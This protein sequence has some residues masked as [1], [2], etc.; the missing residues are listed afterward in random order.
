MSLSLNFPTVS[1]SLNLNFAKT[2]SLDPRITFSRSSSA[3]YVDSE[4]IVRT[5]PVNRARFQH[6]YNSTSGQFVSRGLLIEESRTN[7]SLYSTEFNTNWTPTNAYTIPNSIQSPDGTFTGTKL[8]G[9]SGTTRCRI[10]RNDAPST[11]GKIYSVYAKA[12]EWQYIAI[13]PSNGSGVWQM[14]TFN[15]TTGTFSNLTQ[16]AVFTISDYGIIPVGNG[17]YRVWIY[18]TSNDANFTIMPVFNTGDSVNP[19]WT[20]NGTSGI[21]IWGAQI[22]VGAFP[23]SYIPT[24][25][26]FTSRASSATFYN[27]S[28]ILQTAAT[29]VARS[30]AYFPDSSGVFRSAR[31]LLESA[32]TNLFTYSEDFSNSAWTKSGSNVTTNALLAPDGSYT[33][34]F[35]KEDAGSNYHFMYRN[36]G[37]TGA[38]SFSVY[39]KS[40]TFDRFLALR[41]SVSQ[42]DWHISVFDLSNG[43]I[44]QSVTSGSSVSNA[45]AF[46]EKLP[47]GWYR[48]TIT[49]TNLAGSNS[50]D[51][52]LHNSSSFVPSGPDGLQSY[53]GN[54]TSGIYIWGAQL[55]TGSVA[56][57]YIKS[58]PTFTSRASSATYVDVNGTIRTAAINE[59]RSNSYLPDS[60]GVIRSIGFLYEPSA[61]NLY[62]Y[63]RDFS[64]NWSVNQVTLSTNAGLAPDGTNTAALITTNTVNAYNTIEQ[65]PTLST[66]TNYCYSVFVKLVSGSGT[67]SRV[68]FGSASTGVLPVYAS[69]GLQLDTLAETTDGNTPSIKGY[70]IYP[71][72]WVR[73]YMVI[74]TSNQTSGFVAIRFGT[75]S[76][77]SVATFYVWGAQLEQGTFPTS[78]IPTDASTVTR[79]ADVVSSSTTTRAADVS[80]SSSVTRAAESTSMTGA[81]F[82][83]WYNNTEGTLYTD[84]Q[85]YMTNAATGGYFGSNT[86]GWGIYSNGSYITNKGRGTYT[87]DAGNFNITVNSLISKFKAAISI[88]DNTNS[89]SYYVNGSLVGTTTRSGPFTIPTGFSVSSA[90]IGSVSQ[91]GGSF[92]VAKTCYYPK[93][94]STSELQSITR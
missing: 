40:L 93:S 58:M 64:S 19:A 23:T 48:C 78:Y 39:A 79:S 21:Y 94:L 50:R 11:S 54:G 46:V 81:N 3:T 4:G 7:N 29:N 18:F 59:A 69:W 51:I 60:T 88:N 91:V 38:Q 30:D 90:D 8:I 89:T 55:E 84:M 37:T 5:S 77:D 6:E 33:A 62:T 44:V 72:G 80:S 70:Q 24:P 85:G 17:W 2:K 71:N 27:S 12:A 74:N 34:N 15:L 52:I 32:S 66:N 47:N 42:S 26:T 92:T 20:G 67:S 57:S 16:Y 22:E 41:F 82:T 73:L 65:L 63:S 53:A 45:K 83:S 13:G 56:T 1:P 87:P 9:N 61:T 25:A 68:V 14:A 43:N 86:E 49:C 10:I 76:S 36:P 75:G 31:L 35:F 28:G